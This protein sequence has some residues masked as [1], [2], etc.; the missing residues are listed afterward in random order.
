MNK[1]IFKRMGFLLARLSVG[2]EAHFTADFKKFIEY[3]PIK[4]LP[5]LSF[6]FGQIYFDVSNLA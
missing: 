2:L 4:W 3:F 5:L 6:N 1:P